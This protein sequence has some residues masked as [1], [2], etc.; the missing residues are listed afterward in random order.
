MGRKQA[1]AITIASICLVIFLPFTRFGW[2]IP[3]APGPSGYH[4]LKTFHLPGTEWWDYLT[5]DS[6]ARILYISRG[7][8]I[9]AVNVDSGAIVGK[10][11]GL[12]DTNGLLPVPELG[13]G[14]V[15]NEGKSEVVIVDL[16]TLQKIGAVKTGKAPDS[17]AYEPVTK[18]VF[19][20]NSAGAS[21]TVIN[22]AAG[23]VAGTV[24]LNGQPEFVVADGKGSV[25]INITDKNE[26]AEV[27]AKALKVVH[28]WSLAPGEGPSGISMDRKNR[29]LFSAC[30]NQ[31]MI[32]MN[33][34]TGKVVA[35]LRTGAG[36]DA[37][38]FDPETM[39]AFAPA[40]GAGTLTIIHE[41]SPDKFSVVEEIDTQSGARTATLDTKTHNV[42]TVTARHGHGSTF[43]EMLPDTFVVLVIG[44]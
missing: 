21:A 26:V 44:K 18:R 23:T 34:D 37:S 29:R 2:A 22:A 31:K 20:M 3:A 15:T 5:M 1:A 43:N 25:F 41:D 7:N 8:H 4:A 42:I 27:D 32:V 6:D 28:H 12:D 30:D 10:V 13:H 17:F 14:F 38:V 40:G 19:I 11:T 35:A 16:K 24:Q 39:N 9:D 36:T 33:A